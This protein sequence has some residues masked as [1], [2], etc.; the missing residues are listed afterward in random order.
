M[1]RTMYNRI[2]TPAIILIL[3]IAGCT[4]NSAKVGMSAEDHRA[5]SA[6]LRERVEKLWSA[7]QAEDWRT[8]FT[9]EDPELQAASTPEEFESWSSENEPFKVVSFSV[10]GVEQQGDLG[11]AELDTKMGVRRFPTAPIRDIQRWETWHRLDGTWYPIP[12]GADDQY[13]VAPSRRDADAEAALRAR[14]AEAWKA[15]KSADWKALFQMIEPQDR[16]QTDETSFALVQNK[17]KFLDADVEWVQVVGSAGV[18]RVDY[19]HRFNDPSLTKMTPRNLVV[20]EDWV[21][22]DGTWYLD[23]VK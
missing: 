8:V 5:R 3:L 14:F 23:V 1:K 18:V 9:F 13:P 22:I 17:I 16:A 20:N 4:A 19:K 6:G 7:R 21:L 12:R 2:E 15:R 11:W 10:L